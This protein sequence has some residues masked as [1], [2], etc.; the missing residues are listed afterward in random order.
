MNLMTR[1]DT[2]NWKKAHQIAQCGELAL[3]E[4]MDQAYDRLRNERMA[5]ITITNSP[6]MKGKVKST[7]QPWY[8]KSCKQC[9]ST[10][11]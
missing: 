4:A 2:G 5:S 6:K 9:T 10:V 1:E 3:E 8:P 11:K 7:A